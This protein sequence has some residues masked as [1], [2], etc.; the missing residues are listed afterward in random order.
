MSEGRVCR[1]FIENDCSAVDFASPFMKL[2]LDLGSTAETDPFSSF[3]SYTG[4]ESR[5]L[6]LSLWGGKSWTQSYFVEMIGNANEETIRKYVQDQLS[7]LD[8]KETHLDQLDFF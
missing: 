3:I 4:I 5:V 6:S 8:Q 7:E 1:R 2:T